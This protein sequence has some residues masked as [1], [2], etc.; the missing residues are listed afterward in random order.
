MRSADPRRGA[1]AISCATHSTRSDHNTPHG[2]DDLRFSVCVSCPGFGVQSTRATGRGGLRGLCDGGGIVANDAVE[3]SLAE[4][5]TEAIR[6]GKAS[7]PTEF[8]KLVKIH[9]AEGRFITDYEVS[10]SRTGPQALGAVSGE[11]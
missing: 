10:H 7:K 9:E 3:N 4:P 6:K 5:E 11:T 1:A 8:G 2:G